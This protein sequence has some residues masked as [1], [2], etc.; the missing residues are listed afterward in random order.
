[1]LKSLIDRF[2]LIGFLIANNH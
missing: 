2:I 1:V